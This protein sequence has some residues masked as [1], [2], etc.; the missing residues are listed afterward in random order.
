[1]YN[2]DVA[3]LIISSAMFP[4]AMNYIVV[5]LLCDRFHKLNEEFSK[6][7][8]GRGEFHGHFEQ[9]RRR[10][11]VISHSVKEAD[12]FLKI[13]N[14]ACFC[15]NMLGVV[16]TLFCSIFYRQNT[17]LYS[18]EGA[19]MYTTWLVVSLLGLLLATWLAVIVN[20]MV[21]VYHCNDDTVFATF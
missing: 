20:K 5:S 11:Q 17:V 9:F 16:V 18:A 4:Q 10:H 1:M 13:S 2:R 15:C 19:F 8:G 3:V 12:R 6:C 7:I 21:S 14:V